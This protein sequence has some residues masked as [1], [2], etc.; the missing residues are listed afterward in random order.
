MNVPH[1]L[2]TLCEQATLLM[3]LLLRERQTLVHND[4]AMLAE[5]T[6]RKESCIAQLIER[7]LELKDLLSRS[8]LSEKPEDM[9]VWLERQRFAIT[10]W[11][12]LRATLGVIRDLNS[13]NGSIISRAERNTHRLLEILTGQ[14]SVTTYRHNGLH[15]Q[16]SMTRTYGCA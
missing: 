6:E 13:V 12:Q 9:P 4:L 2:K 16:K 10:P 5:I 14:P 3:D 1:P 8:G 7:E 15:S 11:Y